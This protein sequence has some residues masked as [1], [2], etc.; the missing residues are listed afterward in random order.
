MRIPSRL[1]RRTATA[2]AAITTALFGLPPTTS[3]ASAAPDIAAQPWHEIA[4]TDGDQVVQWAGTHAPEEFAGTWLSPQD[5][6]LVV[7]FTRV[8][9][10]KLNDLRSRL[11]HPDSLRVVVR[12]RSVK[13]LYAT[14]AA[15]DADRDRLRS[16]GI[17]V[18]VTGIDSDGNQVTVGV[19]TRDERTVALLRSRYGDDALRIEQRDY[20]KPA[21]RAPAVPPWPGGMHLQGVCYGST[22]CIVAGCSANFV[23]WG[24]LDRLYVQFMLTAGHCFT[25]FSEVTTH[26][27]TVGQVIQQIFYTGARVDAEKILLRA[28]NY[29]PYIYTQGT[30]REIVVD[31]Q[32]FQQQY[33]GVC[34]SGITTDETCGWLVVQTHVTVPIC[35]DYPACQN[36]VVLYDQ[37]EANHNSIAV[38]PG[39]SGGPVYDRVAGGIRGQGIVSAMDYSQTYMYYSWLANALADTNTFLCRQGSC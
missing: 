25:W 2:V 37:V 38:G 11:R 29:H 4:A 8:P 36:I 35:V 1:L 28:P 19:R 18:T 39:D 30:T 22:D 5:E 21:D 24:Y 34:K 9:E 17:H 7:A 23:T 32:S 16:E 10:E 6:R 31:Y 14:Q 13:A 3:V 15:I 12:Q 20:A 26:T 33:Q 27:G